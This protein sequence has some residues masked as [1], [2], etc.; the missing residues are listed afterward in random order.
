MPIYLDVGG[1]VAAGLDPSG[2]F[3]LVVS[4]SGRGVFAAGSWERAARDPHLA[5]P[6]AGVAVD[7]GPI[8]GI[9]VCVAET[10]DRGELCLFSPN[11][12][13][14]LHYCEGTITITPL[15]A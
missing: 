1:L 2:S 13:F 12:A 8:A 7:I 14:G 15:S 6:E 9:P 11:G 10:D 3:L 4:H 5:Y